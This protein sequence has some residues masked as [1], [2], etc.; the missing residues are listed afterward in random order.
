MKV[1]CSDDL[2]SNSSD[3]KDHVANI[4]FMANDIDNE[5][6]SY[7]R[8]CAASRRKHQPSKSYLIYL[9]GKY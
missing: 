5:V 7:C 2:D 4:C 1:T 9:Y 6:L 8:T 3:D